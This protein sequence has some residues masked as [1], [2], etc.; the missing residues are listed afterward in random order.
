RHLLKYHCLITGGI[1]S[2]VDEHAL[3]YLISAFASIANRSVRTVLYLLHRKLKGTVDR[4]EAL[5]FSVQIKRSNDP[6]YRNRA[7]P[8]THHTAISDLNRNKNL[9]ALYSYFMLT[10]A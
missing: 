8:A 4:Q 5:E 3:G 10:Q 1:G 6:A 7:H 9:T 2:P